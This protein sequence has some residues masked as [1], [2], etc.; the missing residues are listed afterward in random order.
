MHLMTCTSTNSSSMQEPAA[1]ESTFQTLLEALD[2]PES[3]D[4]S[5]CGRPFEGLGRAVSET[6]GGWGGLNLHLPTHLQ[7]PVIYD[8]YKVRGTF[9]QVLAELLVNPEGAAGLARLTWALGRGLGEY[10]LQQTD[11][12]LQDMDTL[13]GHHTLRSV[14]L[15]RFGAL[16]PKVPPPSPPSHLTSSLPLQINVFCRGTVHEICG[17]WEQ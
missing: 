10:L 16:L 2:T 12:V 17:G 11:W 3:R 1:A 13:M 6:P 15:R 9:L 5:D 7:P 14:L 4:G 8:W